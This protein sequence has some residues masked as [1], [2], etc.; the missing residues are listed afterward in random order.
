[1]WHSV[2]VTCLIHGIILVQGLSDSRSN[3]NPEMYMNISEIIQYRG[4]PSEEYDVVT[5][6]GYI[7]SV[8]RIPHGKVNADNAGPKP[9]VFLQHGLLADG[10]SWII[11]LATNS[12][13]FILADAGYD[14]WIGNSRGNT[15]SRRHVNLSMHQEEFWAF[16]YDEMAKYDHP[17]VIDFIVQKTGQEKLYYIGH[18]EGTTTAF[19]T[20]STMPQL[21]QRIKMYFALAP[22]ATLK[23]AQSLLTKLALLPDA[24]I[25]TV[26]GTKEFIRQNFFADL[27][28]AE[29]CSQGMLSEFCGNLM[30]ELCGFNEKNLNMSRIYV[31]ITHAPAGTSVQNIIHWKQAI[32][33]GKLK[34]YDWGIPSN[35]V[36]Y[37]QDTPPIYNV[38][39][40]QVPT[41]MWSGGNDWLADPIDVDLLLPQVTNLVY[42]KVI[43]DWNHLDFIWGLDA[44]ERM[45]NEILDLMR[46]NT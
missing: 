23:N 6:D 42:H 12:L 10:S 38:T 35:K 33:S 22:V 29:F 27:F 4:Y 1:M 37:D 8:N 44:P 13:G 11:N 19:I 45:Y 24:V 25:K 46:K 43:P 14:V 9:V 15:W 36:H 17:A 18:S 30:F 21:A 41:A 34:A 5:A 40:M 2:A 3:D 16:S 31:Y 20:F 28:A 7:L 39:D 26:V 32:K